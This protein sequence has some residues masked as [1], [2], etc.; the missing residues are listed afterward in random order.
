M[1]RTIYIRGKTTTKARTL[2]P[3]DLRTLLGDFERSL[4][5]AGKE[6]KT[7]RIYGDAAQR[8]IDFAVANGMATDASAIAREHV[9]LFMEDQLSRFKPTT[10][11]QR[12]SRSSNCSSIWSKKAKSNAPP[13]S[14]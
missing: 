6:P 3:G 14:G 9:K 4:R 5:A 11:N 1:H 2:R 12:Y 10:A 7:V 13:W 8:L